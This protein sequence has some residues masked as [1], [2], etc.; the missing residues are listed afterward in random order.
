MNRLDEK[1]AQLKARK[2]KALIAYVT[3]GF[4]TLAATRKAALELEKV[5]V[6][7]I[8][9]G[10]PFSDPIADGPT[11]QYSSHEALKGGVTLTA[12]LVW[13]RDLRRVSQV[14]LVFMTYMNPLLRRG[15]D[16]FA[17]QAAE[18][19][20]DGVIVPDLI[21][22]EAGELK[23]VLS[24]RGIHLIFLAA[25]TTPPARRRAIARATGGFLY[26][27]SVTGVTGARR[28]I[29]PDTLAFLDALR[30]DSPAPVAVGFGISTP[31]QVRRFASHADGVIVGSV[32]VD[33]LRQGKPLGAL[34][35]S[36]RRALDK[37]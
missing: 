21:M 37:I 36:F 23:S 16:A 17:R 3:G 30:K 29:A 13:V 4:P 11:I 7:V 20:V 25:P 35:A 33:R 32:L 27:V 18:A 15:L 14:P 26:A 22:E 31:E 28:N 1:F 6:D 19:G 10:V 5:G 34:A 12:L 2:K 24:A 8:E 9:I